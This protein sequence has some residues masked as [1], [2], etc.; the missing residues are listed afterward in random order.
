MPDRSE[1]TDPVVGLLTPRERECLRLVDQHFSSKQIARELG[2]SKTSVDTYCDR[3]RKKLGVGDRYQ[4]AKLLRE[5]DVVN[6]VLIASGQDAIRTDNPSDCG[7][8][9]PATQGEAN[10]RLAEFREQGGDREGASPSPGNRRLRSPLAGAGQAGGTPS[11]LLLDATRAAARRSVGYAGAGGHG[12][13]P[14][15]G[16][17]EAGA[18]QAGRDGLAGNSL[19]HLGSPGRE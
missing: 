7:L 12:P 19:P 9:E 15:V 8:D 10:G 11:Q 2:M 3:A 5:V 13:A 14:G 1:I 4:A 16:H 18:V 6:P 17:A